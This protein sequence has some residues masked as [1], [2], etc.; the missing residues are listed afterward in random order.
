MMAPWGMSLSED[1][2]NSLIVFI[3]TL[4]TPSYDGPVPGE[5]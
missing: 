2:I 5:S 1:E 3:R 4:A